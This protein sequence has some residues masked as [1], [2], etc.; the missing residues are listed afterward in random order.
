M[1]SIFFIENHITTY[2]DEEDNLQKFDYSNTKPTNL[3]P[4]LTS[5]CSSGDFTI[6]TN[7]INSEAEVEDED[8]S[9]SFC[10]PAVMEV[11]F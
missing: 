1:I 4:P 2:T 6:T 9:S 10:P 3:R 11:K 8:E 5:N 7:P